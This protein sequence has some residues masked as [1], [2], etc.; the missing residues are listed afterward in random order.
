MKEEFQENGFVDIRS[1]IELADIGNVIT[2]VVESSDIGGKISGK[3]G[4]ALS[5]KFGEKLG[6]RG[7]NI[8]YGDLN[9]WVLQEIMA[10]EL[11]KKQHLSDNAHA[12]LNS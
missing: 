2:K 5:G 6:L 11:E 4:Y 10:A 7:N 12:N 8:D 1:M 9:E 3:I